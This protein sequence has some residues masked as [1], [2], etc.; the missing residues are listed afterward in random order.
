MAPPS[1]ADYNVGSIYWFSDRNF[2]GSALGLPG[3]L[4][5][6]INGRIR[7][8]WSD[9]VGDAAASSYLPDYALLVG[10]RFPV[11]VT[12]KGSGIS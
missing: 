10:C 11:R 5:G 1:C 8:R 7:S 9:N 4:R 2:L 3:G 12:V 6:R